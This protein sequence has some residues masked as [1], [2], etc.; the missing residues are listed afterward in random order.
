MADRFGF[1]LVSIADLIEYRLRH[2]T[3]V[4]REETVKLPTAFGDFELTA[5]KH[6]HTGEVHLALTKGRWTGDEPVLVRV[7]SS[8]VTGDIF[9]SCRCDC[10]EQLH[11][12]MQRVEAE[13][14]GVILYMNQE[15]RGIGLLN[16]LKAYKL[17]EGGMDTVEANLHL[18]FKMDQRE[19]GTGA[20]ILRDLG[21]KRCAS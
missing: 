2:E 6:K 19:Y 18:G 10:G 13:G 17:Q 5:Y 15:G 16:K 11:A 9:G 20:Q 12:A 3:L 7:H 14:K 8:C 21:V 4:V 1:K